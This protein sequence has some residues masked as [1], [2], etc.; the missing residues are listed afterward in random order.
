MLLSSPFLRTA[1]SSRPHGSL[2][3]FPRYLLVLLFLGLGLAPTH[4]Q[5]VGAGYAHTVAVRTD[6]TL[7]AWG[8]VSS[9]YLLTGIRQGPRSDFPAGLFACRWTWLGVK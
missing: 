2:G 9:G 6:G 1:S 4:A 8:T 3:T 7:W 5:R